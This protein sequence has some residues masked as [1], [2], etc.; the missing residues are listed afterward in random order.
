MIT[1]GGTQQIL[2]RSFPG[3]ALLAALKL[4][5]WKRL[6]DVF[7]QGQRR[8]TQSQGS[9]P[10]LLVPALALTR[11]VTL[12][13]ANA[14]PLLILPPSQGCCAHLDACERALLTPKGS[15]HKGV[16]PLYPQG[17]IKIQKAVFKGQG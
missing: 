14:M 7:V 9:A 15:R 6:L 4:P 2:T 3:G 17:R 5:R 13:K 8:T 10:A 12:P 16:L 1:H 11:S